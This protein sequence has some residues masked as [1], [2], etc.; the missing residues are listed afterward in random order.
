M[1]CAI[2]T[3]TG[4]KHK[5][6]PLRNA[7]SGTVAKGCSNR[8]IVDELAVPLCNVHEQAKPP[9]STAT[10]MRWLSLVSR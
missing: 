5:L 10:K 9:S 6:L 2:V 1:S 3:T 8:S 7:E 4:V